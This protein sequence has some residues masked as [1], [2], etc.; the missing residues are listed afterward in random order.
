VDLGRFFS[1]L[2]YT[3]S[4][5]L[6][7]RGI[8]PSQGRCLHTTTQ[9][10]NKCTQTSMPRMG[11]KPTIPLFERAKTVNVLDRATTGIGV[12]ISNSKLKP[13]SGEDTGHE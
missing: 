8:S 11:F 6:L 5:G 13:T 3:Q 4:V 12:R 1:F 9:T 7:G 10:E 2:I